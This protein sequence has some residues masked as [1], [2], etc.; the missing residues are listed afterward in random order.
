[1]SE[2]RACK[3]AGQHRSTQ[4]LNHRLPA[5]D[6]AKLRRRLR[7]IAKKHP[8]YGY[9]MAHRILLREGWRINR[10]RTQRVWR[11]EVLKRPVKTRKTRRHSPD[12]SERLEATEPNE[13]WA[14][15][16]QF[17]E[18]ADTR[19][20]KLLNIVDEYTREALAMR[21]GRTCTADDVVGEIERLVAERGAPTHLRMDNGP[22]LVAWALQEWC[23]MSG[24]G[25][26]YIDPGSP[27]Q[28]PYIESFNGRARDELLNTEEFGSLLEAQ[29]V[30]EAWRIEYCDDPC[31]T[32]TALV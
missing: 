3:V 21:V 9:K 1:V 6:D 5:E 16:F 7:A 4:R 2:R 11:E 18:T 15:D 32:I 14:L 30:V 13:V 26:T 20:L 19:R 22:E 17:D 31:V 27:W 25:T 28:T 24:T 8:R 23:R 12:S 10:K 29:V